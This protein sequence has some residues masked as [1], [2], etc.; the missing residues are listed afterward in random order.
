LRCRR[1]SAGRTALAAGP[2]AATAVDAVLGFSC[3]TV[4]VD[5]PPPAKSVGDSPWSVPRPTVFDMSEA[6]RELGYRA[7][8]T[9]QDSLPET[10]GW[11]L[12]A[13][14]ERD[15]REVFPTLA[16]LAD[17]HG[18]IFNYAAEDRWLADR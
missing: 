5:G 12:D 4:L 2:P 13:L 6:E 18:S 16:R 17:A 9:Y 14:R 15:W 1:I 8:T 11:T 7:V 10:I 3:E